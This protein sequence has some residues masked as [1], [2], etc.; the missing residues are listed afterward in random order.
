MNVSHYVW[1]FVGQKWWKAFQWIQTSIFITKV[2]QNNLFDFLDQPFNQE[3]STWGRFFR[4]KTNRACFYYWVLDTAKTAKRCQYSK[5]T[6]IIFLTILK[7]HW[8]TS[9]IKASIISFLF[10]GKYL[11]NTIFIDV[12]CCLGI[13]ILWEG[14]KVLILLTLFEIKL[15]VFLTP[16]PSVLLQ[17]I[18]PTD[19]NER[20]SFEIKKRNIFSRA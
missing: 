8:S 16:P 12:S 9:T 14:Q 18:H 17:Y 15:A 10:M 3:F 11:R 2:F 1:I 7:T 19:I 20:R 5:H 13:L 6:S 4:K